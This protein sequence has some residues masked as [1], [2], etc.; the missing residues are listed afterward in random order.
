MMKLRYP[1]EF[2]STSLWLRGFVTGI[3][4]RIGLRL[5]AFRSSCSSDVGLGIWVSFVFSDLLRFVF[6]NLNAE[7]L[8]SRRS[9]IRPYELR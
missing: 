7:A 8:G 3:L 6:P 4:F 9:S 2:P 5:F 1:M